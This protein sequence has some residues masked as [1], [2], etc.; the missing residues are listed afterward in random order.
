MKKLIIKITD[1]MYEKIVNYEVDA[2]TQMIESIRH[3]IVLPC[4]L[5]DKAAIQPII[6]AKWLNGDC[7]GAHCS[8]CKEY[9]P[10]IEGYYDYCPRCGAKMW[11]K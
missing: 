6:H 11:E 1:T 7:K 3:G 10:F 2:P 9:T 5:T 4:N 8:N